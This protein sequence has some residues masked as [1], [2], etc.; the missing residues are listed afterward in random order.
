MEISSKKKIT[1]ANN[2]FFEE[3]KVYLDKGQRVTIRVAGNSMNPFL[4]HGDRVVLKPIENADLKLGRIVLADTEQG[5]ILHRIVKIM[6]DEIWL[7]GDANLQQIERLKK[8]EVWAIVAE[9]FNDKGKID[10]HS[11]LTINAAFIWY[12]ARPVRRLLNWIKK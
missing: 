6:D 12:W 4:K 10:V 8:E 9:A 11:F 3:L 7:A 1:L 2:L 5:Y